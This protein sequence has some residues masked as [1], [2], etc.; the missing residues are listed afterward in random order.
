MK[1]VAVRRRSSL[2]RVGRRGT[3]LNCCRQRAV[4]PT[5]RQAEVTPTQKQ[6]IQQVSQLR[7]FGGRSGGWFLFIL[8]ANPKEL[9][10]LW[11]GQGEVRRRCMLR[12]CWPIEVMC[13]SG[14]WNERWQQARQSDWCQHFWFSTRIPFGCPKHLLTS[15]RKCILA[16]SRS[17]S[18][19][20]DE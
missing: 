10:T 17:T 1:F 6:T 13:H 12:S 2:T 11:C 20:S 9:R 7:R 8:L 18:E 16:T 14:L 3:E 5:I 19:L 15:L 4:G